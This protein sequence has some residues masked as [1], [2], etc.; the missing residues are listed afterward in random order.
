MPLVLSR[1]GR[2]EDNHLRRM[3]NEAAARHRALR[4]NANSK[5]AEEI[6]YKQKA[7]WER[8]IKRPLLARPKSVPG[9]STPEWDV[10]R[11]CWISYS[12]ED[13]TKWI[14]WDAFSE[15]WID[16]SEY[17]KSTF[18]SREWNGLMEC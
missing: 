3:R 7:N 15:K 1:N 2:A 5:A 6:E 14:C 13:T 18:V 16:I 8:N 4:L 12:M 9:W 10:Q 17:D 11:A